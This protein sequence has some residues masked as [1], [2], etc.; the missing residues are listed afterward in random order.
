MARQHAARPGIDRG[1]LEVFGGQIVS[2]LRQ[3]LRPDL[4]H[5]VLHW[6]A[7]QKQPRTSAPAFAPSGGKPAVFKASPSPPTSSKRTIEPP[8]S[9]P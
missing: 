8:K 9:A 6:A 1:R 5:V 2:G 3:H 7:M 4:R